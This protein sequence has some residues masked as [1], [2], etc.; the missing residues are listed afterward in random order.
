MVNPIDPTL[1]SSRS[2]VSAKERP[3][4]TETMRFLISSSKIEITLAKNSLVN[5]LR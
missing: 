1:D 5:N 4:M 3:L 2:N